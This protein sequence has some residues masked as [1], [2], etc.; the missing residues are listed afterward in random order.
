MVPAPG[1]LH[2]VLAEA[3]ATVLVMGPGQEQALAMGQ[4]PAMDMGLERFQAASV[5]AMAMEKGVVDGTMVAT[6][7]AHPP[8]LLG[9]EAAVGK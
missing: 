6:T 9:S 7:T 5:T 2:L 1:G 3:L 8:W 4:E